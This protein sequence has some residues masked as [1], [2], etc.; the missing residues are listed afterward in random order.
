[1]WKIFAKAFPE[2]FAKLAPC[3]SFSPY[4]KMMQ[5]RDYY[6]LI[7]SDDLSWGTL[8]S[9]STG[10]LQLSELAD[11]AKLTNLFALELTSPTWMTIEMSPGV[12]LTDRVLR[13]WSEL[14]CSGN[15]FQHLRLLVLRSQRELTERIF[16]YLDHFP[17]LMAVLVVGCPSLSKMSTLDVAR[18]HGWKSRDV[19][20]VRNPVQKYYQSFNLDEDA[21]ED[22]TKCQPST[23]PLLAVSLWGKLEYNTGPENQRWFTRSQPKARKRAQS[24]KRKLESTASVDK[25]RSKKPAFRSLNKNHMKKNSGLLQELLGYVLL[26]FDHHLDRLLADFSTAVIHAE[27]ILGAAIS[28]WRSVSIF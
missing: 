10:N 11:V 1:M 24:S 25:N 7:S 15:A 19:S 2:N 6:K 20:T 4:P 17:S 21:C 3:R 9:V 16:P 28:D 22:G 5:T 14:A 27:P 18:V 26:P 23:L 8:L 13:I 12:S